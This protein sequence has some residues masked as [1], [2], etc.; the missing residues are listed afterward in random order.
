MSFQRDPNGPHPDAP[1]TPRA[2]VSSR[3]NTTVSTVIHF[4]TSLAT[5][6]WT[7]LRG[8]SLVKKL[9]VFTGLLLVL[10]ITL[11][12]D[13]PSIFTLRQWAADSGTGFVWVFCA[14]YVVITQFPIPRTFLTLAS[15]ILFGPWLGTVVA[16]GSTTASAAISLLIVRG[17]L[18]GWMRPRLTH[19]AVARINDRLRHRGWLAVTSLRMIAAVPFSI[20][21]YAAALTS[22]PFLAFV[23]A[24]AVGSAPGT[25]ATVVLG[26]AFVGSGSI[27]AALFTVALAGLGLLGI[28]LDHRLPVKSV[29]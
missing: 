19:P 18:G 10:L 23:G 17:L 13:V 25:I 22:V 7:E 8:W 15:G 24:T 26:D 3:L 11:L 9:G 21:N 12:V 1:G 29:K 2:E 6:A 28:F 14:L 27:S 16:L 20:L 4:F 5:D